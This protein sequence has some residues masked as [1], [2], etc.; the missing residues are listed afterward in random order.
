[1]RRTPGS[2]LLGAARLEIENPVVGDVFGHALPLHFAQPYRP[3]HRA[4]VK[5]RV[6]VAAEICK[7]GAQ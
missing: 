7:D 3:D 1:M 4:Q 5:R 2:D 6:A